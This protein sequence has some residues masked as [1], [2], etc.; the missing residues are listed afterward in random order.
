MLL[1]VMFVLRKNANKLMAKVTAENI[2]KPAYS[3]PTLS[4]VHTVLT[5]RYLNVPFM[6]TEK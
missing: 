5:V 4:K 2:F 3:F 6:M 1:T